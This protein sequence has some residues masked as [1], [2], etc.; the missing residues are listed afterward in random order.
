MH[1]KFY[2]GDWTLLMKGHN[3]IKDTN[4]ELFKHQTLATP[5]I[6][7]LPYVAEYSPPLQCTA[8]SGCIRVKPK[9]I[10]E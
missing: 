3:K 7:N 4:P 6:A 5:D 2:V 9:I 10:K 1:G 8:R